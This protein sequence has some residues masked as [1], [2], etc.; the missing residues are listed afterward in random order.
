MIQGLNP[1]RSKRFFFS[2]CIDWHLGF[3]HAPVQWLSGG[4]TSGV[5]GQDVRLTTCVPV[6]AEDK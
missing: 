3:M 6:S 4:A 2:K 1:G 5:S